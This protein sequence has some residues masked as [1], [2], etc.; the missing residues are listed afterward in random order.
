[1]EEEEQWWITPTKRP[2]CGEMYMLILQ[3]LSKGC[4]GP[5]VHHHLDCCFSRLLPGVDHINA[6]RRV[7][8]PFELLFRA[9]DIAMCKRIVQIL[10]DGSSSSNGLP[11]ISISVIVE[12][13]LPAGGTFYKQIALTASSLVEGKESKDD[14][15]AVLRWLDKGVDIII[16]YY[17]FLRSKGIDPIDLGFPADPYACSIVVN[18][19][20]LQHNKRKYGTNYNDYAE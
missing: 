1:M 12:M 16:R 7:M 9:I 6:I 11:T 5:T 20:L 15:M 17:D 4:T 19:L 3:M 18:V 2:F 10:H 13:P 14:Q 8:S